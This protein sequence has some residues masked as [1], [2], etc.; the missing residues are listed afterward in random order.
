MGQFFCINEHFC[1]FNFSALGHQTGLKG[2]LFSPL[3]TETDHVVKSLQQIMRSTVISILAELTQ[4]S[5]LF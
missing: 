3:A 1:A 5:C 4:D 2:L